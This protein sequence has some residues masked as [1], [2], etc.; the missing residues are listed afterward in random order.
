MKINYY[1]QTKNRLISKAKKVFAFTIITTAA[2]WGFFWIPFF[3]I[4]NVEI[5]N[6]LIRKSQVGLVLESIFSKKSGFYAPKNNFFLFSAEEAEQ[7][8]LESDLGVAKVSKKFPNKIELEFLEIK[9][10]FIYCDGGCYYADKTG[11]LYEVAPIFTESPI[12][13]LEIESTAKVGDYVLNSND[14]SFLTEFTDEIK[15]FGLLTDKIKIENDFQIFL[16]QGWHIILLKEE[17]R[18]AKEISE[19]INLI[20]EQKIKNSSIDYIDMRFPNKA[21][22]KLK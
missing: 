7:R 12:P 2:I 20:L 1:H 9:P 15:K 14:A 22:Y 17:S 11:F 13:F 5:N 16:K 19:K 4:S 6:P 10:K 21:F 3:K 8:I 18:P